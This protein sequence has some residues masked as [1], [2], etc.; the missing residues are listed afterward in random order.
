MNMLRKIGVSVLPGL[1]WLPIHLSVHT[2]APISPW[3]AMLFSAAA[4]I[5]IIRLCARITGAPMRPHLIIASSIA[6][7]LTS[8]IVTAAAYAASTDQEIDPV[9][10]VSML[11]SGCVAAYGFSV[12]FKP[13]AQPQIG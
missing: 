3:A 12:I 8:Y 4:S 7:I 9:L 1:M 10:I 2:F 13:A 11:V 5:L 6:L